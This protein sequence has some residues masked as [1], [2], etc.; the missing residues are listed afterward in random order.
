MTDQQISALTTVISGNTLSEEMVKKNAWIEI[1]SSLPTL[2]PLT[3]SVVG[4]T[5][6]FIDKL[7]I[8]GLPTINYILSGGA[9]SL[10]IVIY[11]ATIAWDNNVK[12]H[13]KDLAKRISNET[14]KS[15]I[16]LLQNFDILT[17]NGSDR[18]TTESAKNH[19]KGARRRL[20]LI[21]E[22]LN[23]KLDP[24]ELSYGK[25]LGVCNQSCSQI[26]INLREIELRLKQI[27][28]MEENANTPTK[29]GSR[30]G[31][32]ALQKRQALIADEKNKINTLLGNNE[33]IL[34]GIDTLMQ[35][36]TNFK[37]GDSADIVLAQQS[38]AN[39]LLTM[40]N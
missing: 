15:F 24:R 12:R 29:N 4:L 26:L 10:C 32:E 40:L 2:A 8:F 5:C 18:T 37:T 31:N 14:D 33:Q 21:I 6:L 11:Q 13:F 34:T 30:Q 1:I 20:E 19:Y 25:F 7:V 22:I 16:D 9:L 38:D 35:K 17:Q 39:K 3:L 28:S 36:L 27:T 23:N